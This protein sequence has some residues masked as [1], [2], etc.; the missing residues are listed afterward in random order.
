MNG[1]CQFHTVLGSKMCHQQSQRRQV[2]PAVSNSVTE[3]LKQTA[4]EEAVFFDLCSSPVW[5]VLY[6]P[7]DD[8]SL[9]DMHVEYLQ[10]GG[11]FAKIQDERFSFEF[12]CL[13]S[14]RPYKATCLATFGQRHNA[15]RYCLTVLPFSQ[16]LLSQP[17][18]KLDWDF[19]SVKYTKYCTVTDLKWC[20]GS[21]AQKHLKQIK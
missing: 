17:E 2:R 5:L 20:G 19:F 8:C 18:L 10:P 14:F 7:L 4:Q 1:E 11:G 16:F 12:T 3:E 21:E 15:R 9:L 13:N 6:H